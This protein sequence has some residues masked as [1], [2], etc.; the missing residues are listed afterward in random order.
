[1]PR[2]LV[3]NNFSTGSVKGSIF[4]LLI[5]T[6]GAGI[7]GL[8]YAISLPGLGFGTSLIFLSAVM[9]YTTMMLLIRSSD[10]TGLF[11][12]FDLSQNLGKGFTLF[13]KIVFFL[14]NWGVLVGYSK[15]VNTYLYSTVTSLF[16]TAN[17]PR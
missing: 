16:S 17:L 7:V 15:L 3:K 6:I 4:T 10:V 8:P 9:N 1:M 2:N 11:N 12:Y 14:N 13:V 5:G